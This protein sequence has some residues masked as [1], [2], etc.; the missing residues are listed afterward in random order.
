MSFLVQLIQDIQQ[1]MKFN[2][3]D[4]F[5]RE[6]L[7]YANI[8]TGNETKLKEQHAN[9]DTHDDCH[10]NDISTLSIGKFFYKYVD[11]YLHI[12]PSSQKLLQLD[13]NPEL[14]TSL[15]FLDFVITCADV[16]PADDQRTTFLSYSFNLDP[17]IAKQ[18]ALELQEL[19]TPYE[20]IQIDEPNS[21]FADGR[22]VR[23]KKSLF[24]NVRSCIVELKN[25]KVKK[26]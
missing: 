22:K 23:R 2:N 1:K 14:F 17:S 5:R 15:I 8:R 26:K 25:N 20:L 16:G 12:L 11:K 18:I 3:K 9:T 19:V 21:Y 24:T 4:S 10:I 7:C 13:S 6:G